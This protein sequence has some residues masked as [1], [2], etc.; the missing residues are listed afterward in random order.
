MEARFGHDFGAVRLHTDDTAAASAAVLDARAYVV[1]QHVVFAAGHY[2]PQAPE[3]RRLLAHE[4]THVLQQGPVRRI[5]DQLFLDF[6]DSAAERE[7]ENVAGQVMRGRRESAIASVPVLVQRAPA[8]PSSI[9]GS[10]YTALPGGPTASCLYLI[11]P[12][13]GYG[14]TAIGGSLT[15]LDPNRA[16]N[17]VNT[18]GLNFCTFDGTTLSGKIEVPGG[19]NLETLS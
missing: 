2:A 5:P 6:P 8:P 14:P 18:G 9:Y 11:P 19:S 3:G 1:G 17:G 12:A 16:K 4:L 13:P 15:D 7:A 10:W